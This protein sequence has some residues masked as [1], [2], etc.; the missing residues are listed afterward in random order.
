MDNTIQMHPSMLPAEFYKLFVAKFKD[1]K[2]EMDQAKRKFSSLRKN[3]T[4]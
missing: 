4:R 2:L 1:S 3:K